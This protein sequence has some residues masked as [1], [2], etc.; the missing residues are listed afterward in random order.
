MTGGVYPKLSSATPDLK[1]VIAWG[2]VIVVPHVIPHILARR[3]VSSV[4]RNARIEISAGSNIWC[5]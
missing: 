1:D 5:F 4:E 2:E 3:R